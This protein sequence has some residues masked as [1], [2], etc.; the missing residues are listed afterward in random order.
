MKTKIIALIT[1]ALMFVGLQNA[2]SQNAQQILQKVDQVTTGPKDVYQKVKI[3]LIDRN[4]RKETRIG[5]LWQK[6][7]DKRLFR[8]IQPA[9]YRG[10][11]ILSLPH[12]VM[13]LYMPAYG[14]VRRI[15]SSVKNQKFAGTDL[16]YDDM[17]AKNYTEKYTA[18]LLKSDNQFYW[19]QLTPKD[20]HSPYSKVILKVNKQNFTPV[21]AESYDKGGHK[22]KTLKTQFVKQGKYWTAKT[23]TV[24]DLK[25][26][27]TTIMTALI[28]KYDQG[29]SDNIFTVR[30]LQHF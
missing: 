1:L 10:I 5:E 12:D 17:Q 28:T 13:Y 9:A 24:T 18:K 23:V 26:H 6:G 20:R 8:F 16:T 4:G 27:H 7:S 2:F 21:Y 30:N 29:L 15:A 22:V 14:R 25:R 11:G 3:T 19:L